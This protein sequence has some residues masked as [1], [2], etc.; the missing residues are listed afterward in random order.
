MAREGEFTIID[1]EKASLLNVR[2]WLIPTLACLVVALLAT[3]VCIIL[4]NKMP[5]FK[6]YFKDL[7]KRIYKYKRIYLY[8]LPLF[9]ML[10]VFIYYPVVWGFALA[11]QRYKNG[12]FVEWV[13]LDNF[14]D[15]FKNEYFLSSV[16]NMFVFLVTDIL[17][18]LVMPV[19][20][21][22]L[23]LSMRSQKSQY[24]ARVMMYIPGI[25][26]GVATMLLWRYGIYGAGGLLNTFFGGIGLEKWATHD[27]L[28]S[29]STALPSLIFMGFPWVGSYLIV[30]GALSGIPASYKEAA[31]LEGC[32]GWKMIFFIDLPMIFAQLKYLFVTSFI[33]SMQ[34]FNRVYLTTEGGPGNATYVPALELYYNINRFYNYGNAAAMGI[35][36]FVIIFVCSKFFLKVKKQNDEGVI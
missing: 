16:G 33:G 10:A 5:N 35:F 24:A 36:L 3:A 13:F 19:V 25:L 2:K 23:L 14:I 26:P 27:F 20:I 34:D 4:A 22:E 12:V 11:F 32:P 18:A 15:V 17:K 7:G 8:L 31:R 29:E 28:G 30:Y 1:G 9:G 21:A 6:P